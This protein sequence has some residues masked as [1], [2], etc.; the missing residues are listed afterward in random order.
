M[1]RWTAGLLGIILAIGLTACGQDTEPTASGQAEAVQGGTNSA[2][3]KQEEQVEVKK[4]DI[5]LEELIQKTLEASAGV[6]SFTMEAD[7]QQDMVLTYGTEQTNEKVGITVKVDSTREPLGVYQV[8]N[9]SSSTGERE[10][11]QYI[12]DEGIYSS[13]A[14]A[15]VK[16]PDELRDEL[17]AGVEETVAPENQLEQFKSITDKVNIADEGTEYVLTAE[18]LG[19]G[20]K[21]LAKSLMSQSGGGNDELGEMINQMEIQE[22]S[23]KYAVNKDNFYPVQSDVVIKANMDM[24]GRKIEM[25]MVMVNKFS[26]YNEV[27]EIKIPQEVKDSAS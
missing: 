21:E 19:E 14:G 1:R 12:T 11:K 17:V 22:I 25:D 7:V 4:D 8:I 24:D 6:K 23:M 3:Q 18:V 15:W 5:T 20:V 13:I 27:A 9:M 10:I 16:Y 2:N 26:N